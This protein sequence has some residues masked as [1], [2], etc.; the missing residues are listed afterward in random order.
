MTSKKLLPAVFGL[1]AIAFLFT[2][3]AALA[4]VD[5]ETS[6]FAP[7]N[8]MHLEE[9]IDTLD[10]QNKQ[11]VEIQT[12]DNLTIVAADDKVFIV[13]EEPRLRAVIA[14]NQELQQITT[15]DVVKVQVE[16]LR[17]I[18]ALDTAEDTL[19]IVQ[20]E[21][22]IV[23]DIQQILNDQVQQEVVLAVTDASV[24]W[25][26][27]TKNLV[28]AVITEDRNILAVTADDKEVHLF[29]VLSTE[30]LQYPQV[31][32][33]IDS[34]DQ[35][36]NPIAISEL[37]DVVV[38][39]DRS[40]RLVLIQETEILEN[41]IQQ[42]TSVKTTIIPTNVE[43]VAA[44]TEIAKVVIVGEEADLIQKLVVDREAQKVVE[45]VTIEMALPVPLTPP[46]IPTLSPKAT[47]KFSPTLIRSLILNSVLALKEYL[48]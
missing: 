12:Y 31:S 5:T 28:D 13:D 20:Q 37:N 35:I 24:F 30:S 46:G 19:L 7:T 26:E 47:V 39:V 2:A 14:E 17:D 25:T 41:S 18:Q 29:K 15:S 6:I 4:A 36:V 21:E 48:L 42:A 33:I 9:I 3:P 44:D 1:F 38:L 11:L 27:S 32:T 16:E 8:G 34:L 22:M 40:E 23:L 43:L 45:T 10:I